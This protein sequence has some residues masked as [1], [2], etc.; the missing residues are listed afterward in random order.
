MQVHD[1]VVRAF[2]SVYSLR[3]KKTVINL[4]AKLYTVKIIIQ[5][6][7]NTFRHFFLKIN[8][9]LRFPLIIRLPNDIKLISSINCYSYELNECYLQGLYVVQLS[10]SPPLLWPFLENLNVLDVYNELRLQCTLTSLIYQLHELLIT[11]N[12]N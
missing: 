7:I 5:P 8:H 11:G 3:E 12:I 10:Q 6:L 9:F 1:W 2:V 4:H